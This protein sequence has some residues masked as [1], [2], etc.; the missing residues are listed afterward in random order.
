[1]NGSE[2]ARVAAILQSAIRLSKLTYR[3]IERELGWS[4]GTVTRL[5][6]GGLE[7]K[8]KHML[9]I[10]GVLQ[11]SPGRLF[12][13]AYPFERGNSPG[14]D[15]LQTLLEAMYAQPAQPA[16]PAAE[17]PAVTQDKI[18]QMVLS[19]LRNLLRAGIENAP[20]KQSDQLEK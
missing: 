6:R 5:M 7:F 10:L 13:V 14:E 17:Q 16:R 12:T 11:F 2:G 18:D 3:D 4:V 1:M 15:R 20:N 8:L 9:S 19:A